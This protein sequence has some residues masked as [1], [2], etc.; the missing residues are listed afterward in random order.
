MRPPVR[1]YLG[2][3]TWFLANLMNAE[4]EDFNLS[5]PTLRCSRSREA[6]PKLF[7]NFRLNR[8]CA[9]NWLLRLQFNSLNWPPHVGWAGGCDLCDLLILRQRFVLWVSPTVVHQQKRLLQFELLLYRVY[10]HVLRIVWSH[11]Q[12]RQSFNWIWREMAF[13][14][15]LSL[16]AAG[17]A[18]P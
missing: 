10:G 13:A 3:P 11:Y 8:M 7:M 4:S 1:H 14:L 2:S 17:L 18:W 9:L 6:R 5:A 16:A 15:L 12:L